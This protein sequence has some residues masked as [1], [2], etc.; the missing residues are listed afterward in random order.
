MSLP[1]RLKIR[2]GIVIGSLC[3]PILLLLITMI[4]GVFMFE[5][6]SFN[7]TTLNIDSLEGP[8]ITQ[9]SWGIWKAC[10]SNM[11]NQSICT[12]TY[13][14]TNP[15]TFII[16]SGEN[17]ASVSPSWIN[18]LFL[19]FIAIL[20]GISIGILHIARYYHNKILSPKIT[21]Y[22]TLSL[23]GWMTI[24]IITDYAVL[25]TIKNKMESLIAN[26]NTNP[27]SGFWLTV[28]AYLLTLFFLFLTWCYPLQSKDRSP[29]KTS[30]ETRN[31]M[32]RRIPPKV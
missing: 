30:Q 12:A 23:C 21:N 8:G 19:H 29:Q 27:V 20:Y 26:V 15:Y 32:A 6:S 3:V 10:Y 28:T 11:N 22:L 2:L 25:Q 1:L 16:I 13:W 9:I 17:K 31:P 14:I 4:P 24:I 5:T 18:A 7:Q